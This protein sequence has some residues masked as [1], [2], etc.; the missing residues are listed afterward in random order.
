MGSTRKKAMNLATKSLLGVL[1]LLSLSTAARPDELFKLSNS[2]NISCSRDLARGKLRTAT[3]RSFTYL[4]NIKTSEFFRCEM[5]L[6]VTRDKKQVLIVRFDGRCVRR[7]PIFSAESN[8]DF[9]ASETEPTN[10]NSFFGRGG[11]AIWAADT[12]RRKVRGCISITSVLGSNIMKC[13]DMSF[14]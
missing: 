1:L 7:A 8:Y 5:S 12:A 14:E 4:F 6:A 13:L 3:C 2:Q 10:M 11:L 9:D